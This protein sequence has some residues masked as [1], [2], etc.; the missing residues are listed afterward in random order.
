M[1]VRLNQKQAVR[2]IADRMAFQA[3]ALNAERV[4]T[5]SSRDEGYMRGEAYEQWRADCEAD[6]IAYVV[7]SYATPIAWFTVDRGW[8]VPAD[9]YSVTTSR[10]QGI[11]RRAQAYAAQYDSPLAQ[12]LAAY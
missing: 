5:G 8:I 11:V 7:R 12:A 2:A 1:A 9:K 4:H 3:G 10:H 6:R